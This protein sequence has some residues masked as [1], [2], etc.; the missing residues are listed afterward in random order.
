METLIIEQNS[1]DDEDTDDDEDDDGG[2]DV[3]G[4]PCSSLCS[5]SLREA[6]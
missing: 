5:L 4:L 1:C 2:E 3:F 6:A